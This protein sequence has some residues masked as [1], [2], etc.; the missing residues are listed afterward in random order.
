MIA[1]ALSMVEARASQGPFYGKIALGSIGFLTTFHDQKRLRPCEPMPEGHHDHRKL[2]LNLLAV[3]FCL[4]PGNSFTVLTQQGFMDT[5][6]S[7]S[8]VKTGMQ[9]NS[10]PP[11]L[12]AETSTL[13]EV[14]SLGTCLTEYK[15]ASLFTAKVVMLLIACF[16]LAIA[17][18]L[19]F[20]PVE[21][22]TLV[23]LLFMRGVALVSAFLAFFS[24]WYLVRSFRRKR[25]LVC[26]YGLLLA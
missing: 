26:T 20:A 25:V 2:S 6:T 3:D 9:H 4:Y 7:F 24:I 10:L 19:W 23:G 8:K 13:A 16:F 18:F 22:L 15:E 21:P 1:F 14:Q 11:S 5:S 12:T 17:I